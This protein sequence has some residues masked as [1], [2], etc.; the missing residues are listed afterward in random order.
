MIT[1]EN[2]VDRSHKP[3]YLNRNGST[4]G[5]IAYN[6]ELKWHYQSSAYTIGVLSEGDM[7][8]ILSKIR[9]LNNASK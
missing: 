4:A 1:I 6:D 2:E 7:E 9:E 3:Y 5:M 8:L